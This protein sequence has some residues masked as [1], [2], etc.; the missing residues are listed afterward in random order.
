MKTIDRISRNLFERNDTLLLVDFEKSKSHIIEMKWH[1][2]SPLFTDNSYGKT[3]LNYFYKGERL[4]VIPFQLEFLLAVFKE[5][6][7]ILN[8]ENDWDDNGSPTYDIQTWKAAIHFLIDYAV[9]LLHDFNRI[10]DKPKIYNG[11]RG[12]I[13]ILWDYAS[14][15]F[16]V[17]IEKNGLNASF[18]ADN[19]TNTQRIRGEFTLDNFKKTLIPFAVQL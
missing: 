10:I 4:G 14:Y 17:N 8:L 12:S 11:P 16:L 13:D 6:E 7:S 15:T 5:S 18:Y 1:E 9:T 3:A 19:A 2:S